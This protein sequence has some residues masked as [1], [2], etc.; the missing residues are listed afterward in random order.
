MMKVLCFS[1]GIVKCSLL[2][3]WFSLPESDIAF[4]KEIDFEH[5]YNFKPIIESGFLQ[6][7]MPLLDL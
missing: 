7:F 6:P 3:V 5:L 4:E 2:N 1:T